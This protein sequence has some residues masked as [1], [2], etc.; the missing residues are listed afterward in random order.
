MKKGIRIANSHLGKATICETGFGQFRYNK[1]TSDSDVLISDLMTFGSFGLG[2][3][4]RIRKGLQPIVCLLDDSSVDLRGLNV[5]IDSHGITNVM[6]D[7]RGITNVMTDS[8]GITNV[9][10]DSRGITNVMTD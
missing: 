1:I 5:S 4:Q 9:M 10:T 7:S 8:H 3:K 2:N 6:T